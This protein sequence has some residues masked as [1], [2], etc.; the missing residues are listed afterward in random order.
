LHGGDP[1]RIDDAYES[2]LAFVKRHLE[3]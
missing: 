3:R 1:T 2:A